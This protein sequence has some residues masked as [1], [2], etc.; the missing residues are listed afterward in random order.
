MSV[1]AQTL[2]QEH[3]SKLSAALSEK[4]TSNDS[5]HFTLDTAIPG[6]KL[7]YSAYPTEA[8]TKNQ[9]PS[10][11]LIGQGAKRVFLG[12][13]VHIYNVAHYIIT[14][15]DLPVTYQI[16][17][18]SPEKPFLSL[19]L[20]LDL[21]LLAEL[22]IAG[23][24]WST[25]NKEAKSGIAVGELTPKLLWAFIRLID[26]L[27]HPTDIPILAP[28]MLKEIYYR[29]LSGELGP[30]IRQIIFD[31]THS[32]QMFKA[33]NWLKENYKKNFQVKT[34]ADLVGMSPSSF[35]SHFSSFTSLSPIQYQKRLRLIEARRLM[36]VDLIDAAD[37]A[38]TVG[39]ESASQ[40]SREYSRLFGAPPSKDQKL[41]RNDVFYQNSTNN[42]K[43]SKKSH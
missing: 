41:L 2:I 17:E 19:T 34:L 30:R 35:H 21:M 36:F 39:Y 6:L 32:S 23:T 13:D 20:E 4:I 33:I 26:L 38:F 10:I 3:I 11:C 12:S 7:F 14:S 5:E 31:K 8:E 18:A 15:V 25:F 29:L 37:A 22:L 42:Y 28:L 24:P 9:S 27:D 43:H 1:L 40:F 16:I